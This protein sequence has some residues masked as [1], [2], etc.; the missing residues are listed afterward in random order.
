MNYCPHQPSEEL[1]PYVQSIFHFKQYM[2]EH[3]IE[4][5]IPDGHIY[6]IFEFDGFVRKVFNNDNLRPISSHSLV[7]LSGMH[8][9]YISI[10]AHENSEMF[11]I[12][13]KPGGLSPFIDKPVSDLTDCVLPAQQIFGEKI[14]KLRNELLKTK[15]NNQ[16]MFQLAETF[17]LSSASFNLNR[18]RILVEHM[19]EA[20]NNNSA[21][22][23]QN[24]VKQAGYSQ[25]QAIHIF[26]SHVGINPK[27]YQRI[28]RFNEVLPMVMSKQSIAWT[29]ICANCYYF[30]Q[31]HFI[32]EFKSFCGYNPSDFLQHQGKHT[33]SNFFPL[34]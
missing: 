2:P 30:D 34:D 12:Q 29:D 32:R 13:F 8:K 31:S 7:W 16:L 11:V 21:T 19:L 17:L 28:V 18:A 33:E 22:Q 6:L 14:L 20:I 4:K 1:E 15:E 5:V 3:S 27:T 10:S 23:L 26:K 9:H 24:I 25:K